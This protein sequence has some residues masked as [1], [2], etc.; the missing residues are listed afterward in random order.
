MKKIN[1]KFLLILIYVIT[2]II[3]EIAF[4]TSNNECGLGFGIFAYYIVF[5]LIILTTS[6]IYSIKIK[7]NKKYL[8]TLFFGFTV[9]LFE[10]TT[11]SLSNM[12]YFKKV[13]MPNISTFILY[14]IISLIGIMIGDFKKKYLKEVIILLIQIFMY[15]IFPI[16]AGPTDAM[17]MVFIIII[18]TFM[19]SLILGSISKE[20]I[21]YYYPI[22]I[23]LSFIPSV[24][25]YYN[26]SALVHSIWYLIISTIG[27]LIGTI[28]YK[29]GKGEEKI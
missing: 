28:I 11:Y 6:I 3:L 23:S 15:Y 24:Y 4:W 5:P 20:K 8:L 13:N 2:L 12:L 26:E 27:L 21:K 18:T 16:F 22:I 10:Y 29:V 19:L 17:G 7:D 14:S 25:M 1:K 9:M